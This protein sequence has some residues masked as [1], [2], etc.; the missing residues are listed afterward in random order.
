MDR[1]DTQLEHD[2]VAELK[3]D[4]QV[5]ASHISVGV[6]N[7]VAT[8][9]GRVSCYAEKWAAE[10][11]ARRVVGLRA[12]AED[13]SVTVA[14]EERPTDTELATAAADALGSDV[15]V[16]KTIAVMVQNG[17]ITL[18]G[19]VRSNYQREAAERVVRSLRGVVSVSS[20]V[21]IDPLASSVDTQREIE[22]ALRR[23]ASTD[24]KSIE[25]CASG[26]TVVLSGVASSWQAIKGA[27]GAA[28]AAPG[29]TRV[30]DNISIS[31]TKWW[32]LMEKRRLMES[33]TQALDRLAG[34]GYKD[35]CRAEE[36]GMR[37][38]LSRQFYHATELVVDE[39]VRFEGPSSADEEAIV[40]AIRNVRDASK[41][42]Y[43]SGYGAMSDEEDSRFISSL[44]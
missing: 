32:P 9:F 35:Q 44:K 34:A 17:R 14:G 4:P 27:V 33:M 2:I 5:D 41:A 13:L 25:V 26:G 22:L 36:G 21:E 28:W 15:F 20:D 11:A 12:L 23:Q 38:L 19:H 7:G 29:T 18:R 6:S 37:F 8:F 16:P 39:I 40:F 3:C 30:I 1:T 31:S 43:C 24:A 10:E 42:T